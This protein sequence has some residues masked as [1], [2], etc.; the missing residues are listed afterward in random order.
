MAKATFEKSGAASILDRYNSKSEAP[1]PDAADVTAT[2][3]PAEAAQARPAPVKKAPAENND[4]AYTQWSPIKVSKALDLAVRDKMLEVVRRGKR[5]KTFT[6]VMREYM[7][8]FAYGDE[9]ICPAG[10]MFIVCECN[11]KPVYMCPVCGVKV[12]AM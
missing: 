12:S 7:G 5:K 11:K 9:M 6:S 3:R 8:H 10:H 2:N 4:E 1:M